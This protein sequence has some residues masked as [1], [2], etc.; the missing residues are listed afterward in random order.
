MGWGG[1]VRGVVVGGGREE[2]GEGGGW[3]EVEI[4]RGGKNALTCNL[5]GPKYC[6]KSRMLGDRLTSRTRRACRLGML[7]T[8]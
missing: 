7:T 5:V 2:G 8:W 4:G 6:M 3:L 1:E